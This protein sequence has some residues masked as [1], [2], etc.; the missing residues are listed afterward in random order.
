[1]KYFN[2]L[3]IKRLRNVYTPWRKRWKHDNASSEVTEGVQVCVDG[4]DEMNI[5]PSC[6]KDKTFRIVQSGEVC[7]D[8][9]VCPWGEP[10]YVELTNLCDGIETCGN[11]NQICLESRALESRG[12]CLLIRQ[13]IE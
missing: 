3:K 7:E 11:E 12:V 8:V 5:W 9:F 1:M 2:Y 13:G 6:G 10:G 4:R